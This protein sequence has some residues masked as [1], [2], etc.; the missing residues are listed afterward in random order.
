MPKEHIKP[1]SE[2]VEAA[3]T[4]AAELLNALG[5]TEYT[6]Y[7]DQLED[8]PIIAISAEEHAVLIGRRGE[9]LHAFQT[10]LNSI[11][12]HRD[13]SA[14]FIAVDVANYK[15]DRI[16]KI[17][18]LAEDAAQKVLDYGKDLELRPMNA[19]ERRIVHMVLADKPDLATESVGQDPFRKV[20]IKPASS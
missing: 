18:R 14:P 9:S 20:I 7:A 15:K 13:A 1:T 4:I 17:M 3:R 2:Q 11:A 6:A 8:Q 5:I 12:R 19:F 16:E 10:L